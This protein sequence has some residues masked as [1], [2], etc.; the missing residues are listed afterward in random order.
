MD[1]R[2]WLLTIVTLLTSLAGNTAAG[3]TPDGV[4]LMEFKNGLTI[5]SPELHNWRASDTSPC[6]WGGITCD[7]TF[8]HVVKVNLSAQ[9]P[10][11]EGAISAS[12][13]KLTALEDLSLDHNLLSGTIPPELGNLTALTTL[14]LYSNNLTGDIPP[15]LGNCGSLTNLWLDQNSLSGT[16]PDSLAKLKSLAS[17]FLA[18]NR[19]TGQVPPFFA[20]L[21][22]LW[23]LDLG[24]NLLTGPL[25]PAL[26]QNT[27][28]VDFSVSSNNLTG[29]ITSALELLSNLPNVQN[30]YLENNS[31]SGTLPAAIGNATTLTALTLGMQTGKQFGGRIPPEIGKLTNL[32]RLGLHDSNF[33]G[34]IPAELGNM[35]SLTSLEL[36][37]NQLSGAIP[38]EIGNL[39]NLELLQL[40]VNNLTG[41][42]P[43]ALG[44]SLTNLKNIS[45]SDNTLQG[46][47]PESFSYMT[48]LE[49]LWLH[50]N[51]LSGVIPL[52]FGKFMPNLTLFIVRN[53]LLKG[54]FP[55][56]LLQSK[57]LNW[58]DVGHNALDGE[59]PVG[60]GSGGSSFE[61][62]DLSYNLFTGTLPVD[63][64]ANGRIRRLDMSGNQFTGGVFTLKFQQLAP[65]LSVLNLAKNGFYGAIP[66]ALGMC[67]SLLGLDLSYNTFTAK[68]PLNLVRLS[69]LE[70]LRLSGNNLTGLDPSMYARWAPTL[71]GLHLAENPWNAPV[72]P[73]I[74]S[75]SKLVGLNLSYGGFT[76][77]IPTSLG[78]L[79][80]LQSLDLSHNDLTGEIPLALGEAMS[81]LTQVN[82]SFNRLT[83][84]LPPEWVKLLVANPDAF[85]GN[86]GLCLNYDAENFCVDSPGMRRKGTAG[87]DSGKVKLSVGVIVGVALG[88]ASALAVFVAFGASWWRRGANRETLNRDHEDVT[89]MNL[90]PTPLP[91]TY[92]DIM[93]A[94]E[95]LSDAYV[96]GRG[97]NGV[98]Y[99]ATPTKGTEIV[100]KKIDALDMKTD[101]VHKSFWKEIESIG[102]AKHKNV[103]RLLG[104]ML[105]PSEV[106]LLL[107]EYVPNGDLRAALHDKKGDLDLNWKARLR[108]AEGVAHGLA[109][110]HNAYDPPVVHRDVTSSNVLLD[111]DLEARISD[112]GLSK[113]MNRKLKSQV[114]WSATSPAVLGTH[115]YIAPE[116]G[117]S[118]VVTPKLDV[119][120]YGVL[121]LE[122]LTGKKPADKS[123]GESLHVAAWVK[124]KVRQNEGRMSESVLDPSLLDVGNLAAKDEMLLVQRIAL[125]CTRESP[126]DRPA[127]REVEEMFRNISQ[128]SSSGNWTEGVSHNDGSWT[129]IGDENV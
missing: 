45:L 55:N 32:T 121:L 98:V 86:P 14:S 40:F 77:A 118:N 78:R 51:Q 6:S 129:E 119:Y 11:L 107:Y 108:I 59:V 67:R 73:E 64:G 22:S 47:I 7:P 106:G 38:P 2:S 74:G 122:L 58:V 82:V 13:G 96:I 94:T 95:N 104:F 80:Q 34:A 81:S 112:F 124:E 76:G 91:F 61:Y 8:A 35:T 75:L 5:T 53:N 48:S 50:N 89:V 63:L 30:I 3:L 115:G 84:S 110:L 56:G 9:E 62:L 46:P 16:I 18:Q 123:F 31:F 70:V 4:A 49:G 103:V 39:V 79:N 26:F 44:L 88:V 111:E 21:P 57:K 87:R 116:V 65:K 23:Q 54:P 10:M 97:C 29:D 17:V 128:K 27:K 114:H 127:M 105:C 24:S 52:D 15:D 71:H 113:V 20:S 100:V 125:L 90:T 28:L 36:G 68:V 43:S 109:Y 101:L 19:L 60:F 37:R 117:Y 99:K 92:E 1:R 33:S 42:I 69:N 72:A 25:P 66:A 83:G 12:L 41:T 126:A 102:K 85:A 120:S 93:A